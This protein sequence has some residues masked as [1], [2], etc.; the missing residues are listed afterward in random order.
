MKIIT[1][2]VVTLRRWDPTTDAACGRLS[3]ATSTHYVS[4]L[5]HT[6]FEWPQP[7]KD[8]LVRVCSRP[9][10]ACKNWP[11]FFSKWR[12]CTRF[13]IIPWSDRHRARPGKR[14]WR[15]K[16]HQTQT[17]YR[18]VRLCWGYH[19]LPGKGGNLRKGDVG[20]FQNI[21]SRGRRRHKASK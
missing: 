15:T 1:C 17:A 16:R 21:V 6:Q 9:T 3:R 19:G 18:R 13:K 12:R 10:A 14:P 4:S 8:I 5:Q 20:G 11:P 7:P 2:V